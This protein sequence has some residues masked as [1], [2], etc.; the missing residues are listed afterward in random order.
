MLFND[1][2]IREC[3]FEKQVEISQIKLASL[4]KTNDCLES[5][6]A[7]AIDKE[8]GTV[9]VATPSRVHVFDLYDNYCEIT[10]IDISNVI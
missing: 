1:F 9:G 10:S 5:A 2:T 6:T 4:V 3:S 8:L 7:F